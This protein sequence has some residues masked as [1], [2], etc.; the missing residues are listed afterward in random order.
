MRIEVKRE[1]QCDLLILGGGLSGGLIALALAAKRPEL[2]VRIVEAGATVGGN[3][4]W[5]FF[6][7]DVAA[8]DRW[9]VEPLIAHRWSNYEVRFPTHARVLEQGYNA[10]ESELL[11]A[12]VRAMLPAERLIRGEVESVAPRLPDIT[13]GKY[14]RHLL[15]YNVT[16]TDGRCIN[17]RQVIDAR[18][19]GDL[20]TLTLGYQKFVG[21]L[22]NVPA[23][24]GLTRPIIMDATVDQTQGYRFVYCLPFSATQV[25]VEDTY[26]TNG[27]ALDVAAL[28]ARIAAYVE[29]QGW[30]ATPANRLETGVLP[31]VM[32]GDFK[33]YWASTGDHAKVGARGGFIQPMTSYSLPDA[34]RLAVAMPNLIDHQG[35]S[36][37]SAIKVRACAHWRRGGYYRMLGIMLFRAADPKDRYKIFERFYKLSPALI[38]RFYAGQS[39]VY[40]KARILMGKPPVPLFRAL[41][42]LLLGHDE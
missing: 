35:L 22:L 25:F 33:A 41:R 34:V 10:V 8:A 9:L 1:D 37:G 13:G 19:P 7:S 6:D 2:D 11:D 20:D 16:L 29:A 31:V 23:G 32:G 12:R 4:I 21:Q 17:T 5:S 40:D 3:H 38:A 14:P 28:S 36:F 18:G 24:H 39:S 30:E 42:A 26:Y 15:S 27:P